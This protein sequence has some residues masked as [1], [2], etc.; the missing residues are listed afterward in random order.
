MYCSFI[1][2][3]FFHLFNNIY[4]ILNTCQVLF[5]ISFH[6]ILFLTSLF[7]W[8]QR[9]EEG[10]HFNTPGARNLVNEFEVLCLFFFKLSICKEIIRENGDSTCVIS[11]F[12]PYHL[13]LICKIGMILWTSTQS[14]GWTMALEVDWEGLNG[15]FIIGWMDDFRPVT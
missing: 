14:T 12:P 15:G 4:W 11:N 5:G 10:T 2:N 1:P 8:R 3:L 6:F 7:W 13:F 9:E